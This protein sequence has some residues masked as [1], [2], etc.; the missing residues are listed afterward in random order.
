MALAALVSVLLLPSCSTAQQSVPPSTDPFPQESRAERIGVEQ[1]A[2]GGPLQVGAKRTGPYV[3]RVFRDSLGR[4][5]LLR[6]YNV[7]SRTL[8]T[9]GGLTPFTD[10]EQARTLTDR[11]RQRTGANVAR[12]LISWEGTHP[13]V[14]RIDTDYLRT[15]TEQIQVLT[16]RGIYVVLDYHQDNFSRH[17]VPHGHGDGAPAWVTPGLPRRPCGPPCVD[18]VQHYLVNRSVRAAFRNFWDNA[19]FP[20]PAGPR[21][22]Q[23]EFLWQLTRVLA[24]L[25]GALPA[26]AFELV[27]GVEPMNEPVDGGRLGVSAAAWDNEKLWPFY[28]RVRTVLDDAGWADKL[29][30]AGP[31]A[32]WNTNLGLPGG[33]QGLLRTGGGHLSAPPGPGYVFAPHFYDI[34]RLGGL[35]RSPP[36][37]DAYLRDF[38]RIR[39]EGRFLELPVFVG[40]FGARV[41][42]GMAPDPARMISAAYAGLA[43]TG[44]RRGDRIDLEAPPLSGAQWEWGIHSFSV[45]AGDEAEYRV[46]PY[47]VE[48]AYPRRIQGDLLS[49]GYNARA[50]DRA[51]NELRWLALEPTGDGP[52]LLADRR[53]ILVLWRGRRSAAPT[54]VYMP[55]HMAPDRLVVVSEDRVTV[56]FGAETPPGAS[57][58]ALL[59]DA[60]GGGSRLLVWDDPAPGEDHDTVHFALAVD[61]LQP[62]HPDLSWESLRH[63]LVDWLRHPAHRTQSPLVW[64]RQDR[65]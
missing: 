45:V 14:D 48:R 35:V 19:E 36:G 34:G 8:V 49:F 51:G 55:L 63:A 42:G 12:F 5:V 15:I 50:R 11:L 10:L 44:V 46:D 18:S 24:Y 17:L 39:T 41:T 58:H 59:P 2:G 28:R 52:S 21:R 4:E 64:N 13:E 31:S 62:P 20:T 1:L 3:D 30:F 7:T 54:E 61:G 57:S 16:D 60:P 40:E 27:L 47:L 33:N 65:R 37:R 53:F 56:G 9:R 23:D 43:A 25:R 38:D 6:G 26:A 32:F 29:V 22:L